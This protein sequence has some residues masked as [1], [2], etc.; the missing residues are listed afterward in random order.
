ML[1]LLCWCTPANQ[2]CSDVKAFILLY[3]SCSMSPAPLR[4]EARLSLEHHF[5]WVG[6]LEDRVVF[7]RMVYSIHMHARGIKVVES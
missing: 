7:C 6:V 4:Q 1:I 5:D 2:P 3:I